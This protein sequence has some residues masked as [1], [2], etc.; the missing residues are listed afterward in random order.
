MQNSQ[1]PTT[2]MLSALFH[3]ERRGPVVEVSCSLMPPDW[4]VY[5]RSV[6]EFV[7]CWRAAMEAFSETMNTVEK[8]R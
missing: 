2:A 6:H 1:S 8:A 3:F 5:A 4:K 7:A